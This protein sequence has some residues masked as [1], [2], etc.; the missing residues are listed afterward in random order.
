MNYLHTDKGKALDTAL[1]PIQFF[2][3]I[4]P[5]QPVSSFKIIR[6]IMAS[7]L[8]NQFCVFRVLFSSP[9]LIPLSFFIFTVDKQ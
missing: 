4:T 1:T 8:D 3:W 7:K 5:T 2:I 9:T 6:L